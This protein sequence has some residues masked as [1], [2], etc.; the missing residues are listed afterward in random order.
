L[1]R[2][3]MASLMFQLAYG[4]R[5]Q[6]DQDP[7]FQRVK[8]AVHQVTEAGMFTSKLV[9]LKYKF[10]SLDLEL[11]LNF[12]LQISSSTYSQILLMSRTGSLGQVGSKLREDGGRIKSVR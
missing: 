3:T 8:L 11:C 2:S 5:L 7:F 6:S 4:Y 10:L 9:H 1:R 12:I